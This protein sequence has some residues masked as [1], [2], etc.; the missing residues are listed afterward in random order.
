MWNHT[1]ARKDQAPV[2]ASAGLLGNDLVITERLYQGK[3]SL[4]Y[5]IKHGINTIFGES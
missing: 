5:S 3:G 1:E 2:L 4:I